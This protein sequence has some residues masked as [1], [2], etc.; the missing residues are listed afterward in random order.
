[1]KILEWLGQDRGVGLSSKAIALTALNAMPKHPSY[2]HDGDD[3]GRCV[4]L[5]TLCPAAKDGLAKLATDGGPVW[6]AL[7]PRWKEIEA[8]YFRDMDRHEAG[9]KNWKEYE[10]YPLMQ[11]IIRPIEDAERSVIRGKDFNIHVAR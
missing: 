6:A 7:V 4:V 9:N 10:C 3:F 1:M 11:S 8:A 5:L 2:P